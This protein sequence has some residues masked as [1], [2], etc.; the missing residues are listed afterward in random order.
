[1]A[2]AL[3][4][5]PLFTREGG[6]GPERALSD[7]LGAACVYLGVMLPEDRIHAP[8]ERLLLANYYRGMRA[9]AYALEEFAKPE[10]ASALRKPAG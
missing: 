7:A 1:V 5:R 4:R 3:G 2:R 6:S 8:N 10:V 9:A